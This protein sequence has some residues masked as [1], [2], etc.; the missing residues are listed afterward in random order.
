MVKSSGICTC[1]TTGS[2]IDSVEVVEQVAHQA[3]AAVVLALIYL[4]FDLLVLF[5][6]QLVASH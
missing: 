1:T 6:D 3:G 2:V 5:N 4:V